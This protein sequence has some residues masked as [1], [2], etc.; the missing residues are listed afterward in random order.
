MKILLLCNKSPFPPREGGPIAMHAIIS[1]LLDAGHQVKVLA[2]NTNKYFTRLEDIPEEYRKSTGI[3]F[4]YIDLS[5]KPSDAL[6]NLLAGQSYHV[7][8][9]FTK[10]FER[11]LAGILRKEEFDVIQLETLFMGPYLP[12][13]RK[14]SDAQVILRA[15]NIEYLIWERT[16]NACRNPI[17]R[18]YLRHLAITLRQ[19]ELQLIGDVDGIAAITA[20]DAEYFRKKEH[21]TPVISIPFGIDTSS[22]VVPDYTKEQFPSLFHI[23]SM[24]WIPNQESIKWFIEKVWPSLHHFRPELKLHLAGREMPEWLLNLN[25][26][27]VVIAGEVEDARAF[28]RDK[29]VMIVPLLSGSGIR[30]K[31]I[32]GMLEGKAIVTTTIGAEGIEAINGRHLL[33]AD[34]PDEFI[35]AIERCI[36]DPVFCHNLGSQAREMLL[37][38]YDNRMIIKKL[39]GFY[40]QL[41]GSTIS[42]KSL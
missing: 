5:L 30:I 27:G 22:A 32:E 2:V 10:E 33:I 13:I 14:Y 38:T 8:R 37:T 7:A 16:A 25:E 6:F 12:L 36:S 28:M 21:G 4:V 20:N 24:N 29:S 40:A 1:G 26:P 18:S 11:K 34:K 15:H 19:Y 9:F 35:D 23:G 17:K 41:I 31:I 39:T 42:E 3:E